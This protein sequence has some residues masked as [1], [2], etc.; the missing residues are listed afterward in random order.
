VTDTGVRERAVQRLDILA[1]QLERVGLSGASVLTEADP[2]GRDDLRRSAER[3]VL[4]AGL[5][6]LLVDARRRFRDWVEGSF[7]RTRSDL[8]VIQFARGAT[9][10]PVADRVDVFMAVDDAVLGTIAREL[11]PDEVRRDLLEPFERMMALGTRGRP[12]EHD[13]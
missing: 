4:Q 8:E 11:I 13:G 10:G 1:R 9:L 12:R 3:P 2:V 7:N 5:D 6:D